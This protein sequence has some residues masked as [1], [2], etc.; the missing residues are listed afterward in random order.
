MHIEKKNKGLLDDCQINSIV[1][2]FKVNNY[3]EEW[4]LVGFALSIEEANKVVK[5]LCWRDIEDYTFRYVAGSNFTDRIRVEDV[6]N[7]K[8]V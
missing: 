8:G 5:A 1:P 4:R 7:I 2:I 3:T 6:E